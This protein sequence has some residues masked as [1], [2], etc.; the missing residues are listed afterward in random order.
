MKNGHRSQRK[1]EWGEVLIG[2]NAVEYFIGSVWDNDGCSL[3]NQNY[4]KRETFKTRL[5]S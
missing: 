5:V 4:V 3:G 1:G 2:A